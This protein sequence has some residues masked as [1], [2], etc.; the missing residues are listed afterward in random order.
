MYRSRYIMDIIRQT[1]LSHTTTLYVLYIYVYADIFS[2]VLLRRLS[3]YFLSWTFYHS[4]PDSYIF[5]ICT[6]VPGCHIYDEKYRSNNS[7]VS[8]F[9][10]SGYHVRIVSRTTSVAGKVAGCAPRLNEVT[11]SARLRRRSRL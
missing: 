11:D 1:S 5:F 7:N 3:P 8:L 10:P 9:G 4:F 2:L 6:H